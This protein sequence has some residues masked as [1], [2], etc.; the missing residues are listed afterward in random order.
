MSK[1]ALETAI[2]L[3]C[4]TYFLQ[5][6]TATN[7]FNTQAFLKKRSRLTNEPPDQMVSFN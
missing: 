1:I 6:N 2:L 4:M 5:E 3:M 7:V